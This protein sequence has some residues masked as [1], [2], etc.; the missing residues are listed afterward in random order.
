MVRTDRP[1]NCPFLRAAVVRRLGIVPMRRGLVGSVIEANRPFGS[2]KI[3]VGP[4]RNRA[5]VRGLPE[6]LYGGCARWPLLS[7]S[8]VVIHYSL[9]FNTA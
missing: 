9:T 8:Q 1:R 6:R 3:L 5:P 2:A 7:R 4:Y